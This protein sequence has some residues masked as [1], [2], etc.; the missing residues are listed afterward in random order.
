MANG[1]YP[2]TQTFLPNGKMNEFT[3]QSTPAVNSL[4]LALN[5]VIQHAGIDY[6]LVGNLIT[7]TLTP[8]AGDKL[9][10][11]Y[12]AS[13]SFPAPPVRTPFAGSDWHSEGKKISGTSP[14]RGWIQWMQQITDVLSPKS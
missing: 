5:G 9:L 3:L 2:T 8:L 11:F 13:G 6:T 4:L 10:A 14:S 7:T 1:L 12:T